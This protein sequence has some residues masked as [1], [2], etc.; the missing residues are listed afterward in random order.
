M[1]VLAGC[2]GGGQ[3]SPSSLPSE[4]STPTASPSP[5][6]TV[7]TEPRSAKQAI[8]DAFATARTANGLVDQ[9]LSKERRGK[10]AFASMVAGERKTFFD[11]TVDLYLEKQY[12]LEGRT[13]YALLSSQAQAIGDSRDVFNTVTVGVCSHFD[14]SRTID[15][16]GATIKEAPPGI[17]QKSTWELSWT[18]TPERWIFVRSEAPSGDARKC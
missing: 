7:P 4:A 11:S 15:A 13:S 5:E 1:L 10:A 2:A 18:G 17:G 6:A 8:D 14:G 3:A 9:A 16:Q 12:F